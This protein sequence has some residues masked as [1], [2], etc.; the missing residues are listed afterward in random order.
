MFSFDLLANAVVAG[1]LLGG[2]YA[3]VSLEISP[4]FGLRTW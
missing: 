2:F 4:T 3:A 1:I